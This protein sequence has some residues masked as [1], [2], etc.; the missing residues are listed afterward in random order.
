MQSMFVIGP[1]CHLGQFQQRDNA[2]VLCWSSLAL[3]MPTKQ[4]KDGLPPI[5]DWQKKQLLVHIEEAGGLGVA[6]FKIICDS[7]PAIFGG[8]GGDLIHQLFQKEL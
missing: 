1:Q 4:S 8:P 7:N 5:E 2:A 6:N 3:T